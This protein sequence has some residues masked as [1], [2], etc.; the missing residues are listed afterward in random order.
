MDFEK[1]KPAVEDITLSDSQKADIIN[2]CVGKKRK[3]NYKPL[4]AAA[5]AIIVI[6]IAVSP[7][8]LFRAKSEDAAIPQK[9]YDYMYSADDNAAGL[10]DSYVSDSK[11]GNFSDEIPE[12]FSSL[13]DLA[14][15][16]EWKSGFIADGTPAIVRFVEHFSISREDFDA[17]NE[18][19][20]ERTCNYFDAD[21][22]YSYL[23][24]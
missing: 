9:N 19:Y 17:A 20:G 14:Q 11:T 2:A 15:Y 16:E 6:V 13:V 8:F 7:G 21:A 3:F 12:E 5:A 10:A 1:I 22:V 18:V 24:K 4:A 23:G